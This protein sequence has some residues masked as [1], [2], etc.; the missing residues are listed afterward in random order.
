MKSRLATYKY[1]IR[2]I[3]QNEQELSKWICKIYRQRTLALGRRDIDLSPGSGSGLSSKQFN[4]LGLV[5]WRD[6]GQSNQGIATVP[7]R[8]AV[9]RQFVQQ[10]Q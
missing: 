9:C 3:S 8:N 6:V 2:K 7:A 5:K 1:P 10:H 4:K